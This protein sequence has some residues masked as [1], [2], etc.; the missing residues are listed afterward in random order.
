VKKKHLFC[1]AALAG[2]AIASIPA[3]AQPSGCMGSNCPQPSTTGQANEK[4]QPPAGQKTG[5]GQ[6]GTRKPTERSPQ[7]SKS[8]DRGK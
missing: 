1:A 7:K 5:T 3:L 2:F 6:S 8:D 4:A